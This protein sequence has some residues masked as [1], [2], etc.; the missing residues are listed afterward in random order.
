MIHVRIQPEIHPINQP[1]IFPIIQPALLCRIW[2]VLASALDA[3]SF[4]LNAYVTLFW[5]NTSLLLWI[6]FW[7]TRSWSTVIFFFT[8]LPTL[9]YK[10]MFLYFISSRNAAPW[11]LQIG[12]GSDFRTRELN[13][14]SSYLACFLIMSCFL[15]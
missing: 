10:N 5:L 4:F 7:M 11:S 14:C 2:Y 9:W 8:G 15:R 1:E 3:Y 13:F 12:M 6:A